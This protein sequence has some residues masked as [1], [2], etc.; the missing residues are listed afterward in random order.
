[1]VPLV[2][3]L[4]LR[5]FLEVVILVSTSTAPHWLLGKVGAPQLVGRVGHGDTPGLSSERDCQLP[6]GDQGTP[7]WCTR[8]QA[9]QHSF[10]PLVTS[11]AEEGAATSQEAKE[12]VGL[13]S[14][15]RASGQG[16]VS[17]QPLPEDKR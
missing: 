4:L 6:C 5:K 12:T 10:C 8:A 13:G 7:F 11:S 14:C 17:S 1:M 9:G 3:S 16:I 15:R 2:I